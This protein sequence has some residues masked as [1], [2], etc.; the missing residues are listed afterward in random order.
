MRHIVITA[1][2]AE[3]PDEQP[4]R[5]ARAF[6]LAVGPALARRRGNQAPVSPCGVAVGDDDLRRDSLARGE[7]HALGDAILDQDR[8]DLFAAP[9]L[10]ALPFDQ[11]HE[12][13]D[14]AA[15]P[16]HRGLNAVALFEEIDEAIDGARM[17]WIAADQQGMKA[18][19]RAQAF[20]AEIFRHEA[21]NAA[22]AAQS[23]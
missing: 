8:L 12:A 21:I 9:D 2:D 19:S 6:N 14:E 1:V 11:T 15:R 18:E 3:I 13:F 4:R 17:E 22:K 5:K 20:V 16:A 7:L 10:A 23:Q